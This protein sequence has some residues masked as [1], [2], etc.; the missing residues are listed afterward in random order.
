VHA[1]L[2]DV[3]AMA[4]GRPSRMISVPAALVTGPSGH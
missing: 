4:A 1:S 3:R 2:Q